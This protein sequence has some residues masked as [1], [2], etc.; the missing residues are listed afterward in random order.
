MYWG[1]SNGLNRRCSRWRF[2]FN[3]FRFLRGS[4]CIRCC[5]DGFGASLSHPLCILCQRFLP[6]LYPSIF[7]LDLFHKISDITRPSTPQSVT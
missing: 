2:Y 4:W 1:F 3:R 7:L 5:S 6:Y